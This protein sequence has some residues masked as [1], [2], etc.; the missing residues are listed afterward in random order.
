MCIARARKGVWDGAMKRRLTLALG[1]LAVS[2]AL[3]E[4]PPEPAPVAAARP[5]MPPVAQRLADLHRQLRIL[6]EQ[7]Q[8]WGAF[9]TTLRE[10]AQNM[11][12][13]IEQQRARASLGAI[14][15]LQS[16]TELTTVQ[17]QD[18]QRL[19]P[20]FEQLYNSMP[21]AQRKLADQVFRDFARQPAAA[22]PMPAG[23][24]Y[25]QPAVAP[26]LR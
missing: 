14:A 21:E 8:R 9:A 22:L 2:P 5:A 10:N 6:P 16:W 4:P 1:L 11:E 7:E 18:M 25:D 23:V 26:V 17:A 24:V 19:L 12:Y 15:Q 20:A 13:L 3:A